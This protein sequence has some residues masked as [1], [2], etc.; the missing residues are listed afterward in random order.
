M[1]ASALIAAPVMAQEAP[2]VPA[3]PNVTDPKGDANYL[4]D[5]GLAG[6]EGDVEGPADASSSAD[7]MAAWFTNDAE[8]VTAHVL[9]E[10]A[11]PSTPSYFY[12]VLVDPTG[13]EKTC[14]WFQAGVPGVADAGTG[15]DPTGSLRNICGDG[16]T[17][18]GEASLAEN[19]DG[20]TIIS[21]K[22][23]MGTHGLAVGMTLGSPN[24]ASRNWP[25]TPAASVT[26]PQVDNTKRGT[27]YV[28]SSGEAT[29]EEPKEEEEPAG[30][31]DPPGKGKKK[32]CG[33][34]KGKQKGA[35]P[36]KKSGKPKKSAE[37]CPPYEPGENG[38]EAETV[39][40]TDAATEEKPVEIKFD[41]GRGLAGP[42]IT[43]VPVPPDQR[44][45]NYH[46]LVV[47]S[48]SAE[49][50]LYVRLQFKDRRDYDLYLEYPSGQEATHSGDFNTGFGT[51]LFTCGKETTGCSSGSDFEQLNGIRTKDCQGWTTD[52]VAYLTE[53]GEVTLTAWLGDIN[54][55]PA[56]PE[57]G[58]QRTTGALATF[59]TLLGR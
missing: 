14:L 5:Q 12:R 9:V 35:C 20:G 49:T 27:P 3:E 44:T 26:A 33:K 8:S 36:G 42:L 22:I 30:K 34:G 29:A 39:T 24:A 32:G 55:D 4:N 46:N 45:H 57:D 2:A 38:A 25:R 23:P 59:W 40:V 43:G 58:G 10:G 1:A 50:G 48:D 37:S 13:G 7:I 16:S 15:A 31:S 21:I 18:D 51:P 28:I 47:D 54:V 56:A 17:V 41:A 6:G 52:S 53:G 19:P 11:L